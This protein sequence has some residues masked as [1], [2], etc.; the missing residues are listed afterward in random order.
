MSILS[1]CQGTFIQVCREN[2]DFPIFELALSLFHHKNA[3][4]VGF[5]SGRTT[6]TPDAQSA[7]RKFRFR[8]QDFR[9]D[10]GA[11][12]VELR[13]AAKETGFANSDFVEQGD[14]FGLASGLY[15][16]TF[17]I[18]V[19]ALRFQLFHASAAAIEKEA[20]LVV[21]VENSGHLIN[22]V[23]D[24]YQFWVG[25]P[26]KSK[27][28]GYGRGRHTEASWYATPHREAQFKLSTKFTFAVLGARALSRICRRAVV[29]M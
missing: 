23:A 7:Q 29:V 14:Q 24:A 19:Q 2:F 1:M 22:Q 9:N 28:R 25:R 18:L 27:S 20:K 5:F 4:R 3:E 6:G 8:L 13:L 12:R 26:I 15:G 16:K 10:D 11:Q 17:E 21:R